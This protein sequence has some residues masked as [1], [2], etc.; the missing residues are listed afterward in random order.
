MAEQE[1]PQIHILL[2]E[3]GQLTVQVVGVPLAMALGFLEQAKFM[4]LAQAS[5]PNPRNNGIVL[6]PPGFRPVL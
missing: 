2:D 3:Y 4:L 5:R 1:L 6:P